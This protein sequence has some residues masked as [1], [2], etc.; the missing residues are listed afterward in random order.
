MSE[1]DRI[2]DLLR[3]QVGQK[4]PPKCW[5]DFVA[6]LPAV[7]ATDSVQENV[8]FDVIGNHFVIRYVDAQSQ[9]S[10]RRI[11]VRGLGYTGEE[12]TLSAFCFERKAMRAFQARRIVEATNAETGEVFDHPYEYFAALSARSPTAEALERSTPGIQIL[13]ALAICDR[14][15]HQEEVQVILRYVDQHAT[16][17]DI[18]WSI[19]EAYVRAIWPDVHAFDH[20]VR[21][22]KYQGQEEIR[23][24]VAAA[25]KLIVADG[26]IRQ[27]EIELI[28]ALQEAYP[29]RDG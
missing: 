18:D 11:L 9:Q 13:A 20:A 1:I 7:D 17:T 19:V 16:H 10:H 23:R 27:E 8:E 5:N 25:K 3:R 4:R 14:D 22:L 6:T 24:V 21:R 15:L 28:T 12:L 2:T 26:I 29:D